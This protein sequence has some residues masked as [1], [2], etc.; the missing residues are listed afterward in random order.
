MVYTKGLIVTNGSVNLTQ[1]N[2]QITS[3]FGDVAVLIGTAM[4]LA[5]LLG[6]GYAIYLIITGS[7][8]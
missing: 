3:A 6:L 5:V 1:L 7:G 4:I 8:S 2:S